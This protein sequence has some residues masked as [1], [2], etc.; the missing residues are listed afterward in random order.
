MFFVD[1]FGCGRSVSSAGTT[2][3]ELD[4][5][6]VSGDLAVSNARQLGALSL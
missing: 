4:A 2:S 5:V 6:V 3:M 1:G